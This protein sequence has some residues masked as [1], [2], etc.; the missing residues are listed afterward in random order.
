MS[1]LFRDVQGQLV[2]P[3]GSV[4]C[5]G[6]FDGLHLGHQALVARACARARAAGLSAVALSF[7]P[8][9]REFFGGTQAPP[10]LRLPRARF[11]GLREQGMDVVGL[12][13]F[14]A[15]LA[16][17]SPEDFAQ[18]VL[19]QRLAAREVWVGPGFRF[20]KARQGDLASLQSSGARLGFTAHEIEP[21][22]LE[23]VQLSS[24]ALRRQLASGDLEGAAQ[25]LGRR[26]AISGKVVRGKQLGRKLGYPTA[27][28]RLAGKRP[29][30]SGIYATWVHGVGATPRASVSSL[31]TRP[32]VQGVEPLLEAHLFDFDGDLYGQRINVEFVAKLRD[33]EKFDDLPAL[34]RQ[35]DLDAEQAR[36][37]LRH[38][39]EL[40]GVLA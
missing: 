33:E 3:A 27:N 23:G 31:G 39:L 4:V 28:V 34:V 30:L 38:D 21:V 16:S 5:I 11:E 40:S 37:A 32:T 22:S 13:R 1:R 6:A 20:G 9:P 10:R 2:C 8:L 24:T 26:Y 17:M 35:M 7:E 29:A 36:R 25:A 12:L 14:N 19:F 18:R 15:S